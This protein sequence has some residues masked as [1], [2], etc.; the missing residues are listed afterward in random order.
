MKNKFNEEEEGIIAFFAWS[1]GVK[2]DEISEEMKDALYPAISQLPESSKRMCY[3]MGGVFRQTL[4]PPQINDEFWNKN[5]EDQKI[6]K[7]NSAKLFVDNLN[8]N[9]EL[10]ELYLHFAY[11]FIGWQY[12]ENDT[13]DVQDQVKLIV[14]KES[15]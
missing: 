15:N 14:A 3:R 8:L 4:E 10:Y 9:D 12:G 5:E 13:H 6:Y 1:N 7:K 2:I 11:V